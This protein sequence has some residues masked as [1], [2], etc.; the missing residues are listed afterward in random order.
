MTLFS[1]IPWA[2]GGYQISLRREAGLEGRG[3]ACVLLVQK[4]EE[5]HHSPLRLGGNLERIDWLISKHTPSLSP[6]FPPVSFFVPLSSPPPFF[7]YLTPLP[8]LFPVPS[9]H[10]LTTP[11]FISFHFV[12][13]PFCLP[14]L[15]SFQMFLSLNNFFLNGITLSRNCTEHTHTHTSTI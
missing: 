2:L 15:F 11:S 14:L 13:F 12:S 5:G 4:Q 6:F 1:Q 7:S 9:F 10:L 3:N 8:P